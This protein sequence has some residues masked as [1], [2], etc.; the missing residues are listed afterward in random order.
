MNDDRSQDLARELL[1]RAPEPAPEIDRERMLARAMSEYDRIRAERE[2]VSLGAPRRSR[3]P[4]WVPAAAVAALAVLGLSRLDFG[5]G[6]DE[7]ASDSEVAATVTALSEAPTADAA[8]VTDPAGAESA[9]TVEDGAAEGP[10]AGE[11][12]LS[13]E[14]A[15]TT[16]PDRSSFTGSGVPA[17]TGAYLRDSVD[18]DV[19]RRCQVALAQQLTEEL[20]AT[21]DDAD[22]LEFDHVDE[23]GYLHFRHGSAAG[24]DRYVLDPR[25]CHEPGAGLIEP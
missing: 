5:G 16:A 12:A 25:N 21:N 15:T 17:T 22:A 8:A 11:R 23:Q 20:N 6:S 18:P 9:P 19:I 10:G 2:P 13:E 4:V 24:S 3:I 7:D 14:S 1:R